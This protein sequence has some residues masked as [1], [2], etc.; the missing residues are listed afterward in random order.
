MRRAA[1]ALAWTGALAAAACNPQI[2]PKPMDPQRSPLPPGASAQWAEGPE[3]VTLVRHA[4]PVKVRPAGQ[5]AGFPVLYYEKS[6]RIRAGAGVLVDAGGRA[7]VLWP[8][9][10]TITL[11][12]PAS[13]IV[14]STSRGEPTFVLDEL[15]SARMTLQE[16]DQVQLVG[17]A[18]LTG[19][20][21]PYLVERTGPET[22]RVRNQSKEP[23]RVGFR[24]TDF[25]VGP[26]QQID[27]PLVSGGGHPR[28]EDGFRALAG[29]GFSVDVRGEV[30]STP[31]A[32][33]LRLSADG[34][35]EL[36]GLGVRVHLE[37]GE[38]AVFSGLAGPGRPSQPESAG[39]PSEAAARN[40]RNDP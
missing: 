9:G 33:G 16:M 21:G 11:F 19:E 28:A 35:H 20:S 36:R 40:G 14:G 3:E 27:L 23:L 26:G 29:P 37:S 17:G 31:L 10:T 12:G 34:L 18:I 6:R 25:E 15:G 13:G 7:E 38:T 39:Q 1:R 30:R 4:D 8:S 32:D 5:H 22:I 24:T 2:W